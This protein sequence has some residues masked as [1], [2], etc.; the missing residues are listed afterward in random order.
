MLP[1]FTIEGGLPLALAR[2]VAVAGLFSVF[3]SVLARVATM[4]PALARL[5]P[6]EAQGVERRWRLL[7]WTSFVVATAALGVWTWLV[8]GSLADT[9]DLRGTV[10]TLP[11]LLRDTAFGHVAL[12]QLCAL[13]LVALAVARRL[14]WAATGAAAI[15]VA[16]QAGHSHAAAMSA[17]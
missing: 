7:V 17:G 11:I 2:G 10:A 8:A 1:P 13:A 15:A 12:L 4:P 9:P 14:R 5:G 16:L 6:D 3:G